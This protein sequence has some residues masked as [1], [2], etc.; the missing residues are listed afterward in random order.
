M[1]SL[2][3]VRGGPWVARLSVGDLQKKN[4]IKVVLNQVLLKYCEN[5]YLSV[6]TT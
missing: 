1:V 6:S 3:E 5:Q 2:L 4:F